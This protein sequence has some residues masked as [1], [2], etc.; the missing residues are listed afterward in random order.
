MGLDAIEEELGE[1]MRLA[2]MKIWG[3]YGLIRH[4]ELSCNE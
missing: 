4:L 2:T 1:Y 3:D